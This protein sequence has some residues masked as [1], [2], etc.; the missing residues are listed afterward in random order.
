LICYPIHVPVEFVADVVDAGK[1][2]IRRL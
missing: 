2:S 1:I